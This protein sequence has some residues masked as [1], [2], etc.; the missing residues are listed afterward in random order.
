MGE[1]ACLHTVGCDEWSG[2]VS[3]I[4]FLDLKILLDPMLCFFSDLVIADFSIGL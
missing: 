1:R 2:D 4:V 3:G